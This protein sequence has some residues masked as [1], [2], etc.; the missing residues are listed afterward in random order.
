LDLCRLARS[1]VRLDQLAQHRRLIVA[2][3][4]CELG[5]VFFE[6]AVDELPHVRRLAGLVPFGHRITAL[7]DFAL[8]TLGLFPRGGDRPIRPC[9]D[10]EAAFP[11][12][13]PIS[14]DEGAKSLIRLAAAGD[15]DPEADHLLVIDDNVLLLRLKPFHIAFG[16][17]RLHAFDFIACGLPQAIIQSEARGRTENRKS[18]FLTA[19][20]PQHSAAVISGQQDALGGSPYE[21]R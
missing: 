17:V 18:L 14:Q 4:L 6:I 15:P 7:V 9:T 12:L 19:R 20:R 8:E 3:A 10:S 21:W 1:P 11:R 13:D 16:E 5:G 2:V